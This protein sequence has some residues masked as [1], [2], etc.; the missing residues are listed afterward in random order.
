MTVAGLFMLLLRWR[1][2]TA[3]GLLLTLVALL[4]VH[5]A[6][7]TYYARTSGRLQAPATATDPT[8]NSLVFTT[9]SLVSMAGVLSKRL[10]N[11]SRGA[12]TASD[13]VTLAGQG[14]RHGYSITLPNSGGQWAY[15][16]EQPALDIQAVGRTENEARQLM[17]EAVGQV[18]SRLA[19]QQSG[20]PQR[21]RITVQFLPPEPSVIYDTG[22]R[23]RAYVAVLLLGLGLTLGLVMMLDLGVARGLD[24]RWLG[25][26]PDRHEPELTDDSNR[27]LQV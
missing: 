4:S 17:D 26:A 16:F 7:G 19:A 15:N 22:H 5:Q 2:A 6:P 12:Q 3:A 24:R 27:L 20:I 25:P 1:F 9:Q 11:N 14:V 18:S 8:D 10:A 21:G 23:S 13:S